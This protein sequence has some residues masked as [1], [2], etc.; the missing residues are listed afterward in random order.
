[1]I[2]LFIILCGQINNL[3]HEMKMMKPVFMSLLST[4]F[5]IFLFS[6]ISGETKDTILQDE[7]YRGT[8]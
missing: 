3:E 7:N 5:I 4:L 8:L 6:W 2:L 1:M